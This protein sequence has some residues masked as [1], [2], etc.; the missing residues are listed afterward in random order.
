[1]NLSFIRTK[2]FR[3]LTA[4]I[5]VGAL[6]FILYNVFFTSP[7]Y[8]LAKHD[9]WQAQEMECE[10]TL[11]RHYKAKRSHYYY[12]SGIENFEDNITGKI[13]INETEYHFGIQ[14][15]PKFDRF[16]FGNTDFNTDSS[17]LYDEEPYWRVHGYIDVS[18]IDA[19]TADSFKIAVIDNIGDVFPDNI[20]ELT[21]VHVD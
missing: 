10:I 16:N 8:V 9:K 7:Y 5:F 13:V 1:M 11:K 18:P 15:Q 3:I 4:I 17:K 14:I 19:I 6:L 2:K 21:F 20:K 12:Y